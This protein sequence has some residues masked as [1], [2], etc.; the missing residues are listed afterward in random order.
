MTLRKKYHKLNEIQQDLGNGIL[1]LRD[2][3]TTYLDRIEE[4]R[5]TNAYVEVFAEEALQ[6]AEALDLKRTKQPDQLGKLFGLVVAIK[7]VICYQDHQ[8]TAAS[9]ILN[10]FESLFSATAVERLIQEDAIIIGRVNCDQFGMGST[11]ENSVYGPVQNGL[12]AN[13]TPGGSSGGSAVAVQTDTCL[14]S[15]GSDT[16]GSVRQPAAFC[17]IVGF[18]PTYGRISRHGLLA[19]ASSFD[20]IG[21]LGH[22]VEDVAKVLE[23]I[24]G[25]DEYDATARQEAVPA[26]SQATLDRPA[27]IAFYEAALEH[28]S[29]DKEIQE[30]SYELIERL[31]NDGHTVE[32]V[33]FEL[34]DYLIP[35]YYV[36]T[37]AEASANL[38][39]YDGIKFAYRSPNAENLT[40]TYNKSRSEGFSEE[41]KRRIMLGTFVLSAGYYDAYYGKAQKLRRLISNHTNQVFQDYDFILM[42]TAPSTAFELGAMKDPVEMYLADLYTVMANLA[43]IPA[44]ALPLG[45]HSDG[46]PTGIQLMAAPLNESVLLAFSQSITTNSHKSDIL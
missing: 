44:I 23:V 1:S 19:Y 26:Y 35:A 28:P 6:K 9:Q 7:D 13:R 39:R 16:G 14:I 22:S 17:G 4:T 37:T 8:V 3:V 15:L 21:I 43:G 10:G 30:Q 2:L 41:V 45:Q 24:A 5:S 36:L 46:M 32:A 20:Q 42:P 27:K 18:K 25:P 38:S 31:R 33:D 12:D 11:N 29:L 34:I 40:S